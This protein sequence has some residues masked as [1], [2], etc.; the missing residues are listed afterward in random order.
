MKL[1]HK[2]TYYS[3]P[4]HSEY[5]KF[6]RF[7]FNG[8]TFEFQCLPFGLKSAPRAFTRLMTPVIAHFRSSG[9]RT[10]IYLDDILISHQDPGVLQSIF[11][12][13]VSLLEGLGFPINLNQFSQFPFSVQCSILSQCSC[14]CRQRNWISSNREH[15]S[16]VPKARVQYRS[17]QHSW[18][19]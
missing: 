17:W 11:M 10:V 16:Y 3:V 4:V 8:K 12:K 19:A 5:R 1:D 6:L 15:S 2:D 7:V 9:M 14:L 18:D 13:V